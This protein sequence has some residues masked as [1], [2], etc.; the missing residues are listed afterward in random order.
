MIIWSVFKCESER[1]VRISLR[2]SNKITSNNYTFLTVNLYTHHG[3]LAHSCRDIQSSN[4]HHGIGSSF[5]FS[6]KTNQNTITGFIGTL[7]QLIYGIT[8]QILTSLKQTL[9]GSKVHRCASLSLG[10]YRRV[11]PLG[12]SD[13]PTE[14]AIN[15]TRALTTSSHLTLHM[16]TGYVT[17]TH[18][19]S[20]LTDT[21][22]HTY[23]K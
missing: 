11:S 17:L 21:H 1:P 8:T 18:Y 3:G 20:R 9:T 5:L 6:E 16:I 10:P 7:D 13:R 4:T 2:D 22:T 19:L 23:V 14:R 15:G 12:W